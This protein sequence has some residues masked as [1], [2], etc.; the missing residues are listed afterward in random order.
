MKGITLTTDGTIT[1]K[2]FGMPIKIPI[3][4]TEKVSDYM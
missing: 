4:Y 1:I 2:K 3:S